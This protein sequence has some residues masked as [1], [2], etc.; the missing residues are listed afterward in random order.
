MHSD[1]K[2]NEFINKPHFNKVWLFTVFIESQQYKGPG[3]KFYNVHSR[4][5]LDLVKW[6]AFRTID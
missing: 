3:K 4:T 2:D 5:S 1:L 6:A